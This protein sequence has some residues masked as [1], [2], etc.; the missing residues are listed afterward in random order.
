MTIIRQRADSLFCWFPSLI[1]LILWERFC[2]RQTELHSEHALIW[3]VNV[4]SS[5]LHSDKFGGR[6]AG[7]GHRG[8]RDITRRACKT[9]S[10]FKGSG[11]CCMFYLFHPPMLL[12]LM[13]PCCKL[14]NF[15]KLFV[16]TWN[17]HNSNVVQSQLEPS[18]VK[19]E[20]GCQLGQ[21]YLESN[22]A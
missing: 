12:T 16:I 6:I 9:C 15:S 19:N 22:S 21:A 2:W 11:Q 14:A 5:T 18:L 17:K 7:E 1:C 3:V 10:T 13:L 8:Q 20:T 4:Y